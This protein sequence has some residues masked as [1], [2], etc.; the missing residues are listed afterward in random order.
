MRKIIPIL[1]IALAVTAFYFRDRILPRPPGEMNYLGYV[2]GETV[3][4]GAPAAGRIVS[5]AAVKG[6]RLK[7]GDPVFSLDTAAA[8][9]EVARAE[10][11]LHTAEA[12]AANLLTGKRQAELDVYAAQRGE[13]AAGL[14][15][16][17]KELTRATALANTGAAT[18]SRLDQAVSQIGIYEARL[19]QVDANDKAARLP[20]RDSE[21]EAARSRIEEAK[22]TLA[23]SRQKLADL[24][25][26][27]PS[28]A[29]VDDVFFD[30]GEWVA[31][32]QPVAS[33]LPPGA[34]TLR[35]FVPEAAVAKSQR[36]TAITFTCDGCGGPA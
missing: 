22:A 25:P 10:A 4:I 16:A 11:A 17:K 29:R 27:S 14:T 9:D 18:Q 6:G 5:V 31:A 1:I 21:I 3:L 30:P 19:A 15:M 20:A 34:V 32:G 7:Q 36:G 8:K 13:I 26:V 12:S 33:L 24:T 28:E 35:F 2:E 23:Q